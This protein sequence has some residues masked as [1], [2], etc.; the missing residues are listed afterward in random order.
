MSHG[1]AEHRVGVISDS[2]FQ[3]HSLVS[4]MQA[5]SV[6]V[7]VACE[8]ERFDEV[9]HERVLGVECWILVLEDEAL[10]TSELFNYLDELDVPILFGLGLA[11]LKQD[12]AYIS[13]ER[14]LLTKIQEHL[15]QLGRIEDGSTLASI[16]S[17]V[18][19][20]KPQS[21]V[22]PAHT[23]SK[24]AE[25]VWVLAASLGGPAAVKAFLDELPSDLGV[26]FLYAQHVDEH[27]SNV[28]TDVL[29]RHAELNLVAMRDGGTLNQNEVQV[30]PVSRQVYFEEGKARISEDEWPGPYGPS[31][32]QLLLNLHACYGERCHVIVFSG[33]GNDG[34]L[35]AAKMYESGCQVWAQSPSTCASPSMPSSVIDLS[36]T[37]LIDTPENLARALIAR[38]KHH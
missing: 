32:D 36:C 37:R 10:D 21:R 6:D 12:L 31:I 19:R 33:M 3:R 2:A 28:L 25:E 16:D 8:P 35:G 11:P 14:R 34:A 30:V 5:Y 17:E 18:A 29:G 15:G 27:F 38:L 23:E 1:S 4:A 20:T 9:P 24:S 13:W 26:S 22:K 7:K